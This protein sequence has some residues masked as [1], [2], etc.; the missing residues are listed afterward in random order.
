VHGFPVLIQLGLQDQA[1]E[2]VVRD[3][4][5]SLRGSDPRLIDGT[6]DG[7]PEGSVDALDVGTGSTPVRGRSSC[8]D[9]DDIELSLPLGLATQ[10][11]AGARGFA[12]LASKRAAGQKDDGFYIGDP[13]PA[14]GLLTLQQALELLSVSVGRNDHARK[15]SV[16]GSRSRR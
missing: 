1:L 12:E 8:E 16:S 15:G 5:P 10:V 14:K 6:L 9:R 11:N 7:L 3:T 13:V 2:C 4:P